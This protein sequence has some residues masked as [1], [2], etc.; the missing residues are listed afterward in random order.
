MNYD[1]AG[2]EAEEKESLGGK[3]AKGQRGVRN[4]GRYGW[5]ISEDKERQDGESMKKSRRKTNNSRDRKE[6]ERDQ[7]EMKREKGW[8]LRDGE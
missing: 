1:C 3:E 5:K 2:L 6:M 8:G 7:H 4:K